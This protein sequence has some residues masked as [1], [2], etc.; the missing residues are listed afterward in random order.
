MIKNPSEAED[1][2]QQAFLQVF[3]KIGTFRGESGFSTWLHRVTLIIVLMHLRRKKPAEIVFE[4]LDRPT[5]DGESRPERGASDTSMLG[6]IPADSHGGSAHRGTFA[7]P[8]RLRRVLQENMSRAWIAGQAL[9]WLFLKYQSEIF[10]EECCW[11]CLL[12]NWMT[13]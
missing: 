7:H 2:T 9:H 8:W 6:A 11:I 4:D 1:L 10:G 13:K 3:R 5:S 12:R